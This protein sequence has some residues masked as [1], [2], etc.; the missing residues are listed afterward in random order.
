MWLPQP[1]WCCCII[2]KCLA[3]CVCCYK[4]LRFTT[5]GLGFGVIAICSV[6]CSFPAWELLNS[7]CLP[8]E[9]EVCNSTSGLLG[10]LRK[11]V[12]LYWDNILITSV[13]LDLE[14]LG[15]NIH[16]TSNLDDLFKP[17]LYC[18]WDNRGFLWFG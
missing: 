14:R 8:G 11:T 17:W 3:A 12:L 10:L 9:K 15:L 13:A 16:S 5:S 6:G 4:R 2:G 7:L 1:V 18:V